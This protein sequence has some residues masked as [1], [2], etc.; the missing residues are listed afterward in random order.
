MYKKDDFAN[1]IKSFQKTTGKD[2]ELAQYGYYYL[3]ACYLAQDQKQFAANA[4]ASANKLPFDREIREDALFNQAQ[5]AFELSY[6]PYSKA[7]KALRCILASLSR[8]KTQ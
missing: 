7:V 6:D 5:L 8:L 2:D 4:F 1:A 3:A